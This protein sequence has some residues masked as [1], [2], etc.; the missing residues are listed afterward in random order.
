MESRHLM[1]ISHAFKI[2]SNLK[3]DFQNKVKNIN[4]AGSEKTYNFKYLSYSK[5]RFCINDN[6]YCSVECTI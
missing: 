4:F 2:I 1:I 3:I 6:T 5:S